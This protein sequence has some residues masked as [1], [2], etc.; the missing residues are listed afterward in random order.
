MIVI[1][2][3]VPRLAGVQ[4]VFTG[5]DFFP[6]GSI[7]FPVRLGNETVFTKNL[8]GLANS[9]FWECL[10]AAGLPVVDRQASSACLYGVDACIDIV[11]ALHIYPL[12]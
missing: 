12:T 5:S 7:I 3:A 10:P 4:T 11:N 1:N 9:F 6:C 2:P 8:S